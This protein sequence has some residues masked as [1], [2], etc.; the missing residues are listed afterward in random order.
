MPSYNL[1]VILQSDTDATDSNDFINSGWTLNGGYSTITYTDEDTL[2]LGD[3]LP[4]TETNAPAV[5][6]AVNGD[7]TH[8]LV[9]QPI[10]AK[11]VRSDDG[12]GD[13]DTNADVVFVGTDVSSFGDPNFAFGAAEYPGSGWSMNTGDSF[14]SGGGPSDHATGG[15]WSTEG[16]LGGTTPDTGNPPCFTKGMEIR[17]LRGD[18]AVE[19]LTPGDMIWTLDNGFQEVKFIGR[20]EVASAGSLVP[21]LFKKGAIGNTKDLLVS[22]KHRFHVGSLPADQKA[23]FGENSDTLLQAIAFCNGTTIRQAHDMKT[24]EYFQLMFDDHQLVQCHGTISESFQPTANALDLVGEQAQE[25]LEIF[26]EIG[27]RRAFHP[28]SMVRNEVRLQGQP[29]LQ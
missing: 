26:P 14:V 11:F 5:I 7:T 4:N 1:N 24:V 9:G 28:G 22:P 13:S 12:D 3:D 15:S 19:D 17:T 29:K 25:L 21:V 20:R 27:S 8:P 18:I 10:Y 6:T 23:Q 2:G 16:L